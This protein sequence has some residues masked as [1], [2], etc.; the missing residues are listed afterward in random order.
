MYRIALN[1]AISFY[2][3]ESV[4]SRHVVSGEEQLLEAIDEK[5]N[6]TEEIQLLYQWN[7][8]PDEPAVSEGHRRLQLKRRVRIFGH[9]G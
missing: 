6:Q 5:A 2:H 9:A 1:V 7:W 3:R 8:I 4:R